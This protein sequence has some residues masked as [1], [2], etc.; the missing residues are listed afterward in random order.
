[1][2]LSAARGPLSS[3]PA[4]RF[5]PAVPP[6]PVYIEPHARRIVARLGGRTVIDSE[7]ALL[8]HLW[9]AIVPDQ[10]PRIGLLS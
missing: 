6:A 10:A 1:M 7:S 8:V 5:S 2:T 9:R 4:G 3:D